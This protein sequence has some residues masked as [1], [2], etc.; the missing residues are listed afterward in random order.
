MTASRRAIQ[1]DKV[2]F[3]ERWL[4]ERTSEGAPGGGGPKFSASA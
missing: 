1:I 4:G 2:L 3:Y